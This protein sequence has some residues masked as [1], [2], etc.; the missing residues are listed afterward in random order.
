[1]ISFDLDAA[2][3]APATKISPG[4]PVRSFLVILHA[5]FD[6]MDRLTNLFRYARHY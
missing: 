5:F 4:W 6:R 3:R 1:M 2:H